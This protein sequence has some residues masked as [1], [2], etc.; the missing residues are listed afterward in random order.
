MIRLQRSLKVRGGKLESATQWVKEITSYLNEKISGA[1]VQVF[2][3][4]FGNVGTFHWTVDFETLKALDE[5]QMK[6]GTDQGYADLATKAFNQGLFVDGSIYDLI[7]QTL[8]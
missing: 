5:W 7:L 1:D 3:E 6:V 2:I 4:R 8:S